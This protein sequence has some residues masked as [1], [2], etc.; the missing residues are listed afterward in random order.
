MHARRRLLLSL[1]FAVS[2]PAFG[3]DDPDTARIRSTILHSR[4][5]GAHGLG[6]GDRS[7]DEL[8]RNLRPADIPRLVTLFSDRELRVGAQ[9]ALASQC[10]PAVAAV[11]DA[12]AGGRMDYL[13]ASDTLDIV[14]GNGRCPEEARRRARDAAAEVESLRRDHQARGAE[15]ARLEKE[16]DARVQRNGALLMQGGAQAQS[17]SRA[18][19][20]EVYR[21]SL[22]AMGI[23]EGGPMT[24]Q[25]KD[26]AERMYRSMVLGESGRSSNAPPY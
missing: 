14:S 21:R 19:R 9:F 17:L 18:E 6:Y 11:R 25:Q 24:P 3:A 5:M 23:S 4:Q 20:E 15:R 1:A 26:L 10:S 22:K 16:D 12:A 13:D 8:S 7:L 2:G